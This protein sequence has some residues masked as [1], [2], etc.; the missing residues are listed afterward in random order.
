MHI[1]STIPLK[2]RSF[3]YYK[4][5]VLLPGLQSTADVDADG[6]LANFMVLFY[7]CSYINNKKQMGCGA[8]C[9]DTTTAV[10]IANHYSK[11]TLDKLIKSLQLDP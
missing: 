1:T 4:T 2:I 3:S 9:G 10:N 8:L 5:T 11:T 7:F 6:N